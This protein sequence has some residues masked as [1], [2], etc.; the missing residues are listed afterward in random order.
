MTLGKIEGI[1]FDYLKCINYRYGIDNSKGII[2]KFATKKH[3][4]PVQM[5]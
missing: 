5:S 2:A 1:I 3:K 4:I